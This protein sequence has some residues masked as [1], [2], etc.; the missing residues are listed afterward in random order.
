MKKTTIITTLILALIGSGLFFLLRTSTIKPPARVMHI[1]H[2]D[3][4]ESTF[5]LPI[6][7]DIQSLADY[8]NGKI[9]GRFL[10]TTLFL[11]ES[12][13]ERIALTLS[14]AG[15][16][17][18]RSTGKELVCTFPLNVDATLLECRIG[19]LLAKLVKPLHTT[20]IVTLSTPLGLDRTWR[21]KTR[22]RIRSY[23]WVT[24]P[25]V[26][27][28]PFR[29]NLRKTIDAAI[30][31]ESPKLTAML[32]KEIKHAA[33]L[34]KTVD[35]I[36]SDLQHPIRISSKPA[37]VWIRFFCKDLGGDIRLEKSRII[38]FASIKAKMMMVTDTTNQAKPTPLPDFRQLS[39]K[40]RKPHSTVYLYAFTSFDE[41]NRH[42]NELVTGKMITAK[43][44]NI[45]IE[46]I[47]A[48]ASDE[49][50]VVQ[51][52]TGRDLHSKL[53]LKGHPVF[54]IPRQTLKVKNFD[55]ALSTNSILLSKEDQVMHEI[56]RKQVAQKLNLGL[57]KFIAKVPMIVNQAIAR[58]KNGKTMDL[59]IKSLDIKRCDIQMGKEKI[60]FFIE[61]GTEAT[62]KLKKIK[63]GR[64]IKIGGKSSMSS[65]SSLGH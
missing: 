61:A 49:G 25:V 58:G 35:G 65:P 59:Q 6:S 31:N 52:S 13:K 3:V 62:L 57:D 23:Q 19:K 64:P 28:G 41:I 54:D 56:V 22:F 17:T 24:E 51:V 20:L 10:D 40:D 55:F 16:I 45:T 15:D 39:L 12:K 8:L 7:L 36:W 50:L 44:Y 5:N 63:S 2:I 26:S 21:L 38:C 34:Q 32:D 48:Y 11:Q 18:I 30:S 46:K 1:V 29:T 60:H 9:S 4:P 47:N 53:F 37:P 43:G 27:I 33:S 42:L 14:K